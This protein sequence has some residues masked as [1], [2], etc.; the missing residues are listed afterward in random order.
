MCSISMSRVAPSTCA[1]L[2]AYWRACSPNWRAVSVSDGG[3]GSLMSGAGRRAN[4]ERLAGLPVGVE[5]AC[6]IHDALEPRAPEH[7]GRDAAAVA[8]AAEH[9]PLGVAVQLREPRRELGERD[10]PGAGHVPQ[11]GRAHV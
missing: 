6:R 7:A 11:I 10:V 8:A 1:R 3:F 2:T 5:P 4:L 9:R